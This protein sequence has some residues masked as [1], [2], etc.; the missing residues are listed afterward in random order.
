MDQEIE[1]LRRDPTPWAESYARHLLK[2]AGRHEK[3]RGESWQSLVE[4]LTDQERAAVCH[5]LGVVLESYGSEQ[6]ISAL[7]F[8]LNSQISAKNSHRNRKA[9]IRRLCAEYL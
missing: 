8:W 3:P 7:R 1:G 9:Q 6:V 4:R 5:Q 2:R